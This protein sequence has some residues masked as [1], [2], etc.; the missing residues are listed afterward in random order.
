MSNS[1]R[2]SSAGAAD[3]AAVPPAGQ[4]GVSAADTVSA[5]AP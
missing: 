2:N 4:R 3:A 1:H 5:P